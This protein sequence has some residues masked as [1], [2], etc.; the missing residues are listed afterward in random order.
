[1]TRS[2]R[3]ARCPVHGL[4]RSDLGAAKA[5]TYPTVGNHEYLTPSAAGYFDYF[6]GV[7]AAGGR[8]GDRSTGYYS[9]DIGTWHVI[10]LNSECSHI[11]GCGRGSPQ[12]RWL[13]DDL[14]AHPNRCTL[15]YWHEPRFTS[16]SNGNF[17]GA[18]MFWRNLYAAGADLILNG[19]DHDYERFAPQD[20]DATP[21]PRAVHPGDRGGHG[22]QG[23]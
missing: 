5:I 6:D 14:A 18:D 1:M 13:R 2:T 11:G 19:H 9:Y 21:G 20:P 22:R 15:A 23:T 17:T 12:D 7:G 4:V 3:S 8:A 10:V 16:G